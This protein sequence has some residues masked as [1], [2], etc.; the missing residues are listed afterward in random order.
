MQ[1][2]SDKSFLDLPIQEG[3]FTDVYGE[4]GFLGNQEPVYK[5]Y[6]FSSTG[7]IFDL[8]S[9]TKGLVTAPMVYSLLLQGEL[10]L[11]D[12]VGKFLKGFPEPVAAMTLGSLLAHQSGLPAWRNFW[13]N[14]LAPDYP[15]GLDWQNV[16]AYVR[17]V[18]NRVQL[19]PLATEEV[20]SDLGFILLGCILES[21]LQKTLREGFRDFLE[22]IGYRNTE[23]GFPPLNSTGYIPTAYCE[24]RGRRLQGEVHDENCGALGG[25]SGHAGLFG[26]GQALASYIKVLISQ[27]IGRSFYNENYQALVNGKPML[28][29]R[30]GNDPSSRVF[31]G[32][33]GLGHLGFTG[34]A[35]WIDW[36]QQTYGLY[37]TNRIISSRINGRIKVLRAEAFSYMKQRLDSCKKNQ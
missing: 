23:L 37:L 1:D 2:G 21:I 8:A 5:E 9:L 29:L 32:G 16:Q 31:G 11:S 18:F 33:R 17:E 12:Q 19:E 20:Y 27:D 7:T 24:I 22:G 28:G 30:P 6:R 4:A 25:L 34:C 13:I 35:Y 26:S 3:F 10:D 14:R 36:E 15:Q